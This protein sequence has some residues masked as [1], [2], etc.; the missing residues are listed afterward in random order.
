MTEKRIDYE[1]NFPVTVIAKELLGDRIDAAAALEGLKK[2]THLLQ[3][4]EASAREN[5]E[6]ILVPNEGCVFTV[7]AW[8]MI[9]M[10]DSNRLFKYEISDRSCFGNPDYP[11]L[12][13]FN[14]GQRPVL[15]GPYTAHYLEVYGTDVLAV[16]T[17]LGVC[18]KINFDNFQINQSEQA[19]E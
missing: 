12:L 1:G 8:D 2:A 19:S 4:T 5:N 7:T 9:K 11:V 18:M 13:Y 10:Q 15:T 14:K 16:N 17:D 6:H 3:K